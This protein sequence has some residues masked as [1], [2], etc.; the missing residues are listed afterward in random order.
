M[1]LGAYTQGLNK[2]GMRE[3]EWYSLKNSISQ[4]DHLLS[5]P[6]SASK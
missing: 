4:E 6:D 3:P 2:L 1:S 5:N